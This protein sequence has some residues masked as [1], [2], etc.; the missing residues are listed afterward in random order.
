MSKW[1]SHGSGLD[2]L[3]R[4]AWLGKNVVIEDGVRIFFPERVEIGD[5]VYIGHNTILKGYFDNRLVIGSGTWIGPQC[6]I[7][8]AGGITI[9]QN[10][11]I[12]PGVAIMSSAHKESD[13]DEPILHQPI[14]FAPV[15]LGDGCDIGARTT[16]LKGV[17][18]G[19]GVQIGAGAVVSKS[20]PDGAIAAGVPAKVLRFR[21][22]NPEYA[23][24]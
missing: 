21:K 22:L 3:S 18:I 13:T 8:A 10:V 16:I 20:I 4:L 11:G 2:F 6:F 1:K 14:D 12:G 15:Q 9:G 17:K 24:R 7:Y 5:D 19:K 23:K